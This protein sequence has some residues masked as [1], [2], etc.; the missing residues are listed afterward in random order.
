MPFMNAMVKR[1][2][3]GAA[4]GRNWGSCRCRRASD[5]LFARPSPAVGNRQERAEPKRVCL[6]NP[7]ILAQFEHRN[8]TC[9]R[10]VIRDSQSEA[11]VHYTCRGG[12]FGQTRMT[13]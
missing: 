6:A 13:R 9:T 5:D 1:A 10:T 4:G 11:V 12:D 8:A 2:I 3:V 7:D